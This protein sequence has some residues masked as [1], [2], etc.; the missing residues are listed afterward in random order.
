MA[1]SARRVCALLAVCG[2]ASAQS[3]PLFLNTCNA[4]L[5]A[6][7]TWKQNASSTALYLSLSGG[8]MCIDIEEFATTANATV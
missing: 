6:A 8:P 4:S 2:T 3:G 7:Q 1:P 5:A